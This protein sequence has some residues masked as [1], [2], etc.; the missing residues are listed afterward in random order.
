MATYNEQLQ[1]I[2]HAYEKEHGFVPATARDAVMWGV[3]CGLISLPEI[4]PYDQLAEDMSRALREEYAT[5]AKGRRY[6]KNHAVRIVKGHVQFTMW[7]TLGAADRDHMQKAFIQ[8]RQQIVGDCVQLAIDV[9]VYNDMHKGQ[10]PIPILFDFRDD[11]EER[12][13]WDRDDAA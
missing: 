6:R 2:W 8:R 12:R 3:Q 13:H 11:V 1:K 10:P 9:E 5:D 7:A 4:D